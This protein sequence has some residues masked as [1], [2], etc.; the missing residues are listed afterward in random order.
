MWPRGPLLAFLWCKP[1]S[2]EGKSRVQYNSQGGHFPGS[3]A[4]RSCSAPCWARKNSLQLELAASPAVTC[5]S[6]FICIGSIRGR[7]Y[8]VYLLKS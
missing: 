4:L 1:D 3:Q 5:N 2:L 8:I 6:A 7:E